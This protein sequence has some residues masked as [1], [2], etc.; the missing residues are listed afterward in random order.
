MTSQ[1]SRLPPFAP[2]IPFS[3]DGRTG[4][5]TVISYNPFSYRN[6]QRSSCSPSASASASAALTASVMSMTLI[7]TPAGSTSLARISWTGHA[8]ALLELPWVN[9]L[10]L[11]LTRARRLVLIWIL[12]PVWTRACTLDDLAYGSTFAEIASLIRS[13]LILENDV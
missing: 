7:L 5:V 3:S 1:K 2:Q 8:F 10:I 11:M 4:G 9:I 6:S 12:C 13:N